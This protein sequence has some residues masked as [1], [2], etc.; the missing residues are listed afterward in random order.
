MISPLSI[1]RRRRGEPG[2]FRTL[3]LTCA[4]VMSGCLQTPDKTVQG[5]CEAD[6]GACD[7]PSDRSRYP[8]FG[9]GPG[10]VIAPLSFVNGDGSEMNLGQIY[11]DPSRKVLL[12]TTSAGWCTACIEEQPKLQQLHGEYYDRGLS[13]LVVL[14]EKQD[15][16]P[17]D[18]RLARAWK[19][20]YE[21]DFD[22]VADPEFIMQPFYPNGDSSSTPII[23]VI[24]IDTMTILDTMVGFQEAAV[25]ALITNN[26]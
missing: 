25:R 4:L 7:A 11:S 17:A 6:S 22:V 9:T 15:Y 21:L 16:T 12:L 20:R 10:A 26:L 1:V 3:I 24:D 5:D 23:L 14:F 13:V 2:F 8:G 19:A 18:A